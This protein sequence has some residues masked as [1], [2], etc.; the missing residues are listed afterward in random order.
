MFKITAKNRYKQ[1]RNVT[2]LSVIITAFLGVIK[3]VGGLLYNSHSLFADGLHSFADLFVDTMVLIAARF[4]SQDADHSHPYGHQRIET[5]ATL[6]L[7]MI[8]IITGAFIA[9][10]ALEEIVKGVHIVPDILALPIACFSIIANESLFHITK[11]I[12]KKIQ[13]N[14]ILANA[15]HHRSDAASS[16]IVVLGLIGSYYGYVYLDALAA[17]IVGIFIIKM[18]WSYGWNSIKELV[19]TAVNPELL[20]RIQNTI[21][22]VPGVKKMHQ[23]R[24]RSM[25]KDVIVDVHILVSPFISV[26]EGHFI[27]QTVHHELLKN[28]QEVQDVTVHVDPEDD[29]LVAPSSN[30]PDRLTFEEEIFS[31]WKKDF[32]ELDSCILHYLNN[33][34]IVDLFCSMHFKDWPKLE[35]RVNADLLKQPYVFRVRF[36]T[37]SF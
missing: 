32:K 28:I 17:I 13:S 11:Y 2:L 20:A 27:A 29:E 15:W 22:Q 16:A 25:G 8:L 19:D 34:L 12:G 36:F 30:L 9:F 18:G 37:K 31:K 14:L 6:L 35:E 21:E 4:G 3:V 10:D 26:S 1:A 5:A 33:T 7:A 24:S 23:L